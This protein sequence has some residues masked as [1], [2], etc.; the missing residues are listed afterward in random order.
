MVHLW[1]AKSKR[2]KT[3]ILQFH[4]PIPRFSVKTDDIVCWS[5][6]FGLLKFVIFS[7]VFVHNPK[8]TTPKWRLL[9]STRRELHFHQLKV[10]FGVLRFLAPQLHFEPHIWP[11]LP[12]SDKIS[13]SRHFPHPAI[14]IFIGATH[15]LLPD[16]SYLKMYACKICTLKVHTLCVN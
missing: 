2:S 3:L 14:H 1:C 5:S 11:Y 16:Q 4:F 9:I 6:I 12:V 15:F 7:H 13:E 8:Q 10:H